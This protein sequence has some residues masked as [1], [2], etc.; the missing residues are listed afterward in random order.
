MDTFAFQ[1]RDL[2]QEFSRIILQQA[3]L[4]REQLQSFSATHQEGI[5]GARKCFKRLRACYRLLKFS[6]KTTFHQGNQLFRDLSSELSGL[7]DSQVMEQTLLSLNA[8]NP[9]LGNTPIFAKLQRQL[10]LQQ[11][12]AAAKT[13]V[14]V[15]LVSDRLEQFLCQ[16]NQVVPPRLEAKVLLKAIV[17]SYS[18]SRHG[19]KRAHR[20]R[21]DA[22]CHYWRKCAKYYWYQLRLISE[23]C[24]PP[25]SQLD[26][27][28]TLCNLLG[29]HHDLAVLKTRLEGTTSAGNVLWGIIARRQQQL[30]READEQAQSLFGPGADHYDAWL[31]RRWHKTA[32]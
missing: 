6:D 25:Q 30:F 32:P 27:L 12:E 9:G 8:D 11:R 1:A 19:W 7:R 14:Q 3:V 24:P 17:T 26:S 29:D 15:Q 21:D 31:A 4:A 2:S 5:H 16:C 18:A 13:A 10:A 20:S 23:L 22:D 28:A